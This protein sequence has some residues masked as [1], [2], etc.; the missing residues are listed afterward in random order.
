MHQLIHTNQQLNEALLKEAYDVNLFKALK[1]NDE[2]ILQ[3]TKDVTVMTRWLKE[4]GVQ[5][6]SLEEDNNMPVYRG[7]VVLRK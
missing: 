7:S 5:V 6:N 4:L 3:K 2:L 1:E